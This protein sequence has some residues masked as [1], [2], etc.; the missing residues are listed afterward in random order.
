MRFPHLFV[1]FHITIFLKQYLYSNA[2]L[3][4]IEKT[5]KKFAKSKI[6][7]GWRHQTGY[8]WYNSK[9]FF[10]VHWSCTCWRHKREIKFFLKSKLIYFINL[11]IVLQIL[12]E[13]NLRYTKINLNFRKNIL[14]FPYLSSSFW[15]TRYIFELMAVSINPVKLIVTVA[16]RHRDGEN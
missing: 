2:T 8:Q 7:P 9:T 5:F 3:K 12:L 6:P 15:V 11:L 10:Q 14:A 1:L 13:T 16:S 4:F